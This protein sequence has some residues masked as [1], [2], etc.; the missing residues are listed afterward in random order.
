MGTTGILIGAQAKGGEGD[1]GAGGG[2]HGSPGI[3][4]EGAQAQE[5]IHVQRSISTSP[6]RSYA[7][8]MQKVCRRC[9][10]PDS[11]LTS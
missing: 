8:G 3:L 10:S 6:L 5:R 7:E 2:G 4:I 9:A 1:M 11:P